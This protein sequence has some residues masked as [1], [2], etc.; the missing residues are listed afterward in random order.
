MILLFSA[1]LSIAL[2]LAQSPLSL[3]LSILILSL[4]L[5]FSINFSLLSWFSFLI[6]LIYIGGILVIFA[7]FAALQ[8]N[9]HIKILP[10]ILTSSLIS[11]LF[12][13]LSP[14]FLASPFTTDP[15]SLPVIFLFSHTNRPIYISLALI[16][17]LTLVA[18]VKI[19]HLGIGPL[20]SLK[21]YVLTSSQTSPFSKNCK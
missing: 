20:R 12:I 4:L 3:G 18:V 9:Q 2:I 21:T 19:T 8:P 5:A 11:F 14:Q 15:N 1:S 10:I 16:L 17:F 6:F 7:Y 13:L